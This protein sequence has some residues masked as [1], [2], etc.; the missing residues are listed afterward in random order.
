MAP[1]PWLMDMSVALLTDQLNVEDCPRSMVDGSAEKRLIVVG[2]T[3]GG[4]GGSVF[5]G[6]GGGGAGG[7]V[8]LHPEANTNSVSAKRTALIVPLRRARR[9]AAWF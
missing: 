6:A 1:I 4:G 9:T 5:V 7:V 2:S 8:F 3:R